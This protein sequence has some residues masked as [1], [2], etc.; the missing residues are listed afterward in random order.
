MCIYVC[1]FV[2]VCLCGLYV[3]ACGRY[4]Y[5]YTINRTWMV[6]SDSGG[7]ISTTEWEW[8]WRATET[9]GLSCSRSRVERMRTYVCVCV[10]V[11]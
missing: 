4:T 10:C 11:F 8:R 6:E 7:K 5:I 3:F 2:G 1:L 9:L